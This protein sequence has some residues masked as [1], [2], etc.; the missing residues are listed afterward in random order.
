MFLSNVSYIF[1]VTNGLHT[2]LVTTQKNNRLSSFRNSCVCYI[3]V[4]IC[5]AISNTFNIYIDRIL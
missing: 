2:L 5:R 4:L 3:R 1:F